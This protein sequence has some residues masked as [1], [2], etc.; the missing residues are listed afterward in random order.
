MSDD[1]DTGPGPSLEARKNNHLGTFYLT[2]DERKHG[3][4]LR[5]LEGWGGKALG[6]SRHSPQKSLLANEGRN[7]VGGEK[8]HVMASC[9]TTEP[10]TAHICGKME[11]GFRDS[12]QGDSVPLAHT[13]Q[14]HRFSRPAVL[15]YGR[16]KPYG[17]CFEQCRCFSTRSISGHSRYWL[18]GPS[19]V[20]P[21]P[22]GTWSRVFSFFYQ[23]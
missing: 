8:N 10:C 6:Q 12:G 18:D 16:G 23:E 17:R 13:T 15:L 11:D 19:L 5:F 2:D 7:R 20:E 14:N 1:A 4:E 21:V 3:Y 9:S 22:R